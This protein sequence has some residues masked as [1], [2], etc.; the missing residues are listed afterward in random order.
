MQYPH[1]VVITRVV[2]FTFLT[3]NNETEYEALIL[4]LRLALAMVAGNVEAMSDCQLVV[5][6]V[7]GEY[8]AMEERMLK[9][10]LAIRSLAAKFRNFKI[11]QIPRGGNE[12]A[13]S[14]VVFA[15]TT[16]PYQCHKE[17]EV[18]EHPSTCLSTVASIHSL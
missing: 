12:L 7:K 5:S 16:P 3:S 4:S 17:L 1:K 8:E 9:Y 2:R 13:D 15:S 6:Q 11:T 10:L 18:L 14:M